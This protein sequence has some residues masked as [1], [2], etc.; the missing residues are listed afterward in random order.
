LPSVDRNVIFVWHAF[1][2]RESP[3]T[4][5]P[6]P[7]TEEGDHLLV[8]REGDIRKLESRI[9]AGGNHPTIE[10]DNGIGKTSL[11]Q[12]ACYRLRR[13][14][15][16]G[17]SQALF[18]P[19]RNLFQPN[20]ASTVDE[21]IRKVYFEIAGTIIEEYPTLRKHA[22]RA[23]DI[24]EIEA[25]LTSPIL[26]SGGVNASVFGVGGGVSRG[27]SANGGS[28]FADLGFISTVDAWL[29]QLFPTVQAGG[30]ICVIDNLELL[31]TT[32]QAR[33]LL[34]AIRDPLLN[35]RG[36]RWILCGARGI[37][38]TTVSSP[39]LA[40]R[41]SDPIELAPISHDCVA[42]AIR[43]RIE[44][45][46]HRPSATAPVGPET[47]QSLYDI[48]NRNLRHALKS[49]QDFSFWLHDENLASGDANEYTDLFEVW[50]TTQ[51][52]QNHT[53]TALGNRAWQV[54]D[55]LA[56]R[57]GRCSP[58]DFADFDFNSA[59]AMRPHVKALEQENLVAISAEDDADKR[60]K[61]IY[62]TS[63]GWLVRYARNG[64]QPPVWTMELARS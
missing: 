22:S 41:L 38:R 36:L 10:G 17:Q 55:D 23:P 45:C 3:Y 9:L 1:G 58:G 35:R 2:F 49:A 4:T 26:R 56:A 15:E 19:L 18:I 5:E 48:L 40:G 53:Q 42:D 6:V 60:R 64:Y 32:R 8:G 39:R 16:E 14:F 43:K 63:R 61:T 46:G 44:I 20:E 50:L 29:R 57:G 28:G 25:W 33:N 37:M 62:M 24:K 21:F 52:D 11:L 59:T 13:D 51:A 30:F 47:F 34:E 31:E 7:A 54:F 12:V 27:G